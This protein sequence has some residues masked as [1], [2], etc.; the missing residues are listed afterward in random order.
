MILI[1]PYQKHMLITNQRRKCNNY[2]ENGTFSN[3]N[4]GGA[5]F[6]PHPQNILKD[7]RNNGV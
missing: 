1:K 2:N 3:T 4:E 7:T 5:K 6:L